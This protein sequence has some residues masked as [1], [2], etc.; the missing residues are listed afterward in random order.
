MLAIL[1]HSAANCM[2]E[3]ATEPSEADCATLCDGMPHAS[4]SGSGCGCSAPWSRLRQTSTYT[5]ETKHY[6]ASPAAHAY[7]LVTPDGKAYRRLEL[8]PA[9]AQPSCDGLSDGVHTVSPDGGASS[10]VVRCRDGWTL[11][12]RVAAPIDE[13]D[14]TETLDLTSCSTAACYLPRDFVRALAANA[15]Q[16]RLQSGGAPTSD[17]FTTNFVTSAYDDT[18][19][20][21]LQSASTLE[22]GPA[23]WAGTGPSWSGWCWQTNWPSYTPGGHLP[24]GMKGWPN[25]H[26]SCGQASCVHWMGDDNGIMSATAYHAESAAW[27]K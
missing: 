24:N 17:A 10:A 14:A 15:H 11:I 19:I 1:A 20:G 23:T 26:H 12:A 13:E 7:S 3:T 5:G 9:E 21:A 8:L 16:V 18:G 2:F 27:I 22:R 4:G 6:C 25:M